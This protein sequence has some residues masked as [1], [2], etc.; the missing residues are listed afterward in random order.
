[1]YM[2]ES[3]YIKKSSEIHNKKIDQLKEQ[4]IIAVLHLERT[5]KIVRC[6]FSIHFVVAIVLQ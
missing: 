2:D 6:N 3:E 1:M 4:G 5:Y